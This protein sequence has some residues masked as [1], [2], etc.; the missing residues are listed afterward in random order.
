[1]HG[2]HGTGRVRQEHNGSLCARFSGRFPD[3]IQ[4]AYGRDY[5]AH[6]RRRMR[7]LEFRA[8]G[9]CVSTGGVVGSPW[10]ARLD[11]E[12]RVIS[13]R[14]DAGMECVAALPCPGESEFAAVAVES[15]AMGPG[16]ARPRGSRSRPCRCRGGA[17]SMAAEQATEPGSREGRPS[18][19]R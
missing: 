13:R 11:C 10:G 14:R 12:S 8:R 19:L 3:T 2:S 17:D 16:S 18:H 4:K 6:D 15:N 1:M 5:F 7:Y 9:L